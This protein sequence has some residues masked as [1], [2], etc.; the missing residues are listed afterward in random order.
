MMCC[1]LINRL[2]ANLNKFAA[3]E[4]VAQQSTESEWAI[5]K[6]TKSQYEGFS[7]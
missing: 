1:D 5:L 3:F 7:I 4:N 6:V 2:M